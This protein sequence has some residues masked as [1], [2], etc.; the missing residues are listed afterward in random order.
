[1][2]IPSFKI[3]KLSLLVGFALIALSTFSLKNQCCAQ[4]LTVQQPVIRF[5]NV[6]TVV[7]VPDGGTTL[8]GGNSSSASGTVSRGVPGLS[9]I[10][11]VNRLFNNRAIGREDARSTAS[12]TT[13]ILI[14]SELE[15]QLLAEA[16]RQE[17]AGLARAQA[18]GLAVPEDVQRKAEFMTRSIRGRNKR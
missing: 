15:E 16:A 6:G 13:R 14:M 2:H 5:F 18:A 7:S 4:G 3:V 8:L 12:V 11:G 1:M 17:A 10:P 9:G